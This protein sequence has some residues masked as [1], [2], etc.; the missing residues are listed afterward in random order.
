M[1][2]Q[3]EIANLKNEYDFLNQQA[4]ATKEGWNDLVQRRF[5]QEFIDSLPKEFNTYINEL[6]K[7]D[8]S[9]ITAEKNIYNLLE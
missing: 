7:L 5:Y 2:F 6:T 4:S 8:N 1:S 3:P 9:F